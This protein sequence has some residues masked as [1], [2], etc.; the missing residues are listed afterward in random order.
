MHITFTKKIGYVEGV[1]VDVY[2]VHR[3]HSFELKEKFLEQL[4][5]NMP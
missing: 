2:S 3:K 4:V 5:F 1:K